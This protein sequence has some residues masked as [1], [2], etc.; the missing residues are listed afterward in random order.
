MCDKAD[1]QAFLRVTNLKQENEK[2][3]EENDNLKRK[4]AVAE[5]KLRKSIALPEKIWDSEL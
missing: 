1:E 3:K 5:K 2:I 4:L